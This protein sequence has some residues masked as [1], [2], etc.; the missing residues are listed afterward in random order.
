MYVVL[1]YLTVRCL[2]LTG[3]VA[4]PSQAASSQP[5]AS[6]P[7]STAPVL[8]FGDKFKKPEGSWEC[9]VC[10]VQNKAEDQQCV[11]CQSAKPGAKVETKGSENHCNATD[12]FFFF[13]SFVIIYFFLITLLAGFYFYFF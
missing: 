4:T 9:D 5:P 2:K 11:A 7:A 1:L 8:G 13:F 12:V 6:T 10:S 3:A